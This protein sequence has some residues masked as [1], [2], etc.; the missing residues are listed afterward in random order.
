MRVSG[1]LPLTSSSQQQW[2]LSLTLTLF[3]TPERVSGGRVQQPRGNQDR[4]RLNFLLRPERRKLRP[5]PLLQVRP[6]LRRGV[7]V[8][9][10]R[11]EHRSVGHYRGRRVAHGQ[12]PVR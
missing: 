2:A 5:C 3:G 12:V 4:G 6:R 9:R 11:L 7:R 1:W 10:D 8:E